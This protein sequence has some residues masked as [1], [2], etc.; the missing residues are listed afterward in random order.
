MQKKRWADLPL[1]K[2]IGIIIGGAVQFGLLAAG[3][4]DLA[5]RKAD[6]V[7]G[8]RRFWAGFMFFN[9]IGPLAYFAYGR[10]DS[11]LLNRC[12]KAQ[13]PAVLEETAVTEEAP[14]FGGSAIA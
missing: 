11:P 2:R 5:H 4:W 10:K 12:R 14:G 7:R 13:Q 6:E 3:L 9:W 8:D 1:C